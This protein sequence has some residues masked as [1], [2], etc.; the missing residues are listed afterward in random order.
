MDR[1]DPARERYVS[2]AYRLA[3]EDGEWKARQMLSVLERIPDRS[4][5]R[6]YADVGCGQGDV[7]ANLHR[8]LIEAGFPLDATY[9]YDVSP[10]VT[11]AQERHPHIRFVHADLLSSDECFDLITLNDVLEHVTAPQRFLASIGERARYVGIHMP[12]DARLSVLLPD[13]LNHRLCSV[14][15]ISFWTPFSAL[16]LVT[17]AGLLPIACRFT[18]GFMAPSG[19]QHLRQWLALPARFAVWQLSPALASLT[20]GG[21]SLAILARGRTGAAAGMPTA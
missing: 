15:H 12:L 4:S 14:G 10:S 20:T 6:R 1:A 9:G 7:L 16:N 11:H 5:I 18:P 3:V 21:V 13:Q 2:G 8:G 19:R 17:D